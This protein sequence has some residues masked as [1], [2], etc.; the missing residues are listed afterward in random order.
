MEKK[1]HVVHVT[2]IRY[3][4]LRQLRAQVKVKSERRLSLLAKISSSDFMFSNN[5]SCRSGI[6]GQRRV[7]N[8]QT[9]MTNDYERNGMLFP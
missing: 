5:L 3:V 2:E 7:M 4:F 1:K 8:V 9:Q 6:L